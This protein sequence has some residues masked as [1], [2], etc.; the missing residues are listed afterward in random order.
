MPREGMAA[1]AQQGWLL[2][3]A[4]PH[5]ILEWGHALNIAIN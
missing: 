5:W 1:V 4:R 2:Q 3:N